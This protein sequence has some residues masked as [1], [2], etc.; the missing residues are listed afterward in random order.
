MDRSHTRRNS[1][2]SQDIKEGFLRL[3]RFIDTVLHLEATNMKNFV[4]I[5]ENWQLSHDI[6]LDSASFEFF[7]SIED[8]QENCKQFQKSCE[9][10]RG[11]IQNSLNSLAQVTS[12]GAEMGEDFFAN[13]FS[14]IS[15]SKMQFLS[16][17]LSNLSEKY[18][19]ASIASS[20]FESI[21]EIT[22]MLS[23]SREA[24]LHSYQCPLYKYEVNL[25]QD[26]LENPKNS[27]EALWLNKMLSVYIEEWS[28]SPK[29]QTYICKKLAKKLNKDNPKFIG[30]ITVSNFTYEGPSPTVRE[31]ISRSENPADFHYDFFVT[32]NGEATFTIV[33][34]LKLGL[35]ST[36]ISAVISVTDFAGS[37]RICF[38][39]NS[40]DQSWYSLPEKPTL[41]LKIF[42]KIAGKFL[43]VNSMSWARFI[44]N[45]AIDKKL[46]NYIFPKKRSIKITKGRIKRH[47]YP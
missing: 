4:Y 23:F 13:Q 26:I 10:I 21:D 35:L 45:K 24:L 16:V 44:I 6:G 30:D 37:I 27:E 28:T 38:T 1:E 46:D 25:E 15:D 3:D 5:F 31:F 36:S 42:P 19:I 29:F 43:D 40:D 12:T 22:E 18:K 11:N 7:Q 20:Y 39:S 2:K 32:I 9:F 47:Q 34:P 17:L 33:L 8:I 14:A 41:N